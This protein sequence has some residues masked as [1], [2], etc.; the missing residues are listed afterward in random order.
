MK[1]GSSQFDRVLVIKWN[2]L[3]SQFAAW[4]GKN[5]LLYFRTHKSREKG[6]SLSSSFNLRYKLIK[7]IKIDA[8][9]TFT[10]PISVG[11]LTFEADF[12]VYRTTKMV[13]FETFDPIGIRLVHLDEIGYN[14]KKVTS[15]MDDPLSSLNCMK[16]K[17]FTNDFPSGQ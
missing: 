9:P 1:L 11:A 15:F 13:K 4:W 7:Q 6:T 12:F 5:S 14:L 2:K 10:R 8:K 17:G 16:C 3:A